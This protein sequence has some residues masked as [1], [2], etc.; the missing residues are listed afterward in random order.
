MS[1]IDQ[2]E[3]DILDLMESNREMR[4][5]IENLED[6]ID[7]ILQLGNSIWWRHIRPDD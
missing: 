6:N 2:I 7:R 5:R 1:Q 4:K 3:R